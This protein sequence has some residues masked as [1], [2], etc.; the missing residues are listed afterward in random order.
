MR[1]PLVKANSLIFGQ[2]NR[3]R[4]WHQLPR[5]L[6]LLNLRTFRDELRERNLYDAGVAVEDDRPANGGPQ[7]LPK[8]RSY[9]GA[10]NDPRHP[11]MGKAGVR[12]GRNHPLGVTVP[13]KPPRLMTPS[14][15]WSR[16]SC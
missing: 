16:R 12:F 8:H 2:I 6:A 3:V 4:E 15:G 13:E 14:P 5:P 10:M 1:N 7:E 11:E 9:D